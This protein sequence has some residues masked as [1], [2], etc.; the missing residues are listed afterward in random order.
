VTD[1]TS[2]PIDI[3]YRRI[4]S[5]AGPVI[6]NQLTITLMGVIDVIMVGQLGVRALAAVG[7]AAMVGLAVFAFFSGMFSGVNALV[8]QAVGGRDQRAAGVVLWQGLYLAGI[9]ALLMGVMWW[10]VPTLFYWTGATPEVQTLSVDYMRM[11]LLGGLGFAVIAAASN[12]YRGIGRTQ[13]LMASAVVQLLLNCGLNYVL[14]FGKFGAP[15]LGTTGAAIGTSIAQW[16]VGLL[17]FGTLFAAPMLRRGYA[18]TR[19]WRWRPKIFSALLRLSL[20]IGGQL[21]LEVAS[22]TVFTAVIGRLG[23]AQLAATNAA[24]H[25]WSVAFMV[26]VGLSVSGTT[27]V[28]QCIGAGRPDDARIVVRRILHVGYGAMAAAAAVY[29]L[30]PEQIMA[31]FVH[32]SELDRLREFARP[33][34]T[35]V[36]LVVAF[37][38]QFSVVLG[39]LRGAGDVTYP[40]V[41]NLVCPWLLF[42]PATL[43]IAPRFG[44]AAAW[45]VLV[46]NY[47]VMAALITRRA[48]GREWLLRPAQQR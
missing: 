10:G 34:F 29:L 1:V 42:V 46:I 26:G 20:P 40:M 9:S 36:A 19:T 22:L 12:F 6:I 37:D 35:M 15:A 45:G 44:V 23:D 32:N 39:A 4:A 31:V 24:W 18:L 11:R 47:I 25:S 33:L 3:T 13:I 48:R 16:I 38:M 27:L 14:I 43:V 2:P 8:A 30:V 28:A 5:I 7:L 41:V 17:L 21:F